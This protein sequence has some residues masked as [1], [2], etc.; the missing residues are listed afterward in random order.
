MKD[1]TLITHSKTYKQSMAIVTFLIKL[2]L[3]LA[4]VLPLIFTICYSIKPEAEITITP[5]NFFTGSPT[6]DHYKWVLF[7]LPFVNYIKN[8]FIVCIISILCQ[9]VFASFAAYAFA[10]FEFK[11]KKLLFAFIL[12]AMMIPADIVII[13]NYALIQR[14]NLVN[15]Y[16]GLVFPTLIS[17]TSIFMM[18]QYY[19]TIPKELKEASTIDGCGDMRFLFQIAMPLSVPTIASLGL[20]LFVIIY[21]LFL[22][23]LLVTNTESRRTVQIGMSMLV[24][25]ERIEYGLLL[26]GAICCVFPVVLIF[27]FGQKHIVKGMVSGAVKG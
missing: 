4:F 24:T 9:V 25:S 26:A 27:V 3:G 6:P 8:S 22:W 12:S 5:P 20:Y 13:M 17:G 16:L 18:R 11:G 21:N 7:N 23:P 10:F 14:W 19:L 15:T 2:A 1:T